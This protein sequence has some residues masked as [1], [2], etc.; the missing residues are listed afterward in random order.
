MNHLIVYQ[1]PPQLSAIDRAIL[2]HGTLKEIRTVLCRLALCQ[3]IDLQVFMRP[4]Q[5][6]NSSATID[7]VAYRES[8]NRG[9]ER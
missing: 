8:L 1:P 5:Y 4:P 2:E 9:T 6:Y 7:F 3:L